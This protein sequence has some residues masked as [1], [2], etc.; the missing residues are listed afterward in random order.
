M[1]HDPKWDIDSLVGLR[2]WLAKQPADGVYY[3]PDCERCVV[4]QYLAAHGHT[5]R[6]YSEWCTKADPGGL[7][8]HSFSKENTFGA[9]LRNLD[10]NM[11]VV[12]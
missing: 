9:A 12:A 4:G 11:A 7:V 5:H 8:A 2:D 3:W 6:R 1:L 10:A